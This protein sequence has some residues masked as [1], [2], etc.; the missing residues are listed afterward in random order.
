MILTI[1]TEQK[2]I[3]VSGTVKAD[4]LFKQLK[5]FLPENKWKEYSLIF[6][7]TEIISIPWVQPYQIDWPGIAPY[8]PLPIRYEQ[9][10]PN[11]FTI[12][13]SSG[14]GVY[15]NQFLTTTN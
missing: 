1:D 12:T 7:Q 4:E 15:E 11:P 8:Q 3:S 2:T 9:T 6:S 13:M 10:G 14:T 5:Q